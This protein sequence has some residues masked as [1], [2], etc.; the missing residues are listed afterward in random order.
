[1]PLFSLPLLELNILL[2]FRLEL[3]G[4]WRGMY[5]SIVT[6]SNIDTKLA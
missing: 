5:F 4:H 6:N 3:G 1:M 2:E